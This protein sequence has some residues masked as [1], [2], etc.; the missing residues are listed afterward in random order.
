MPTPKVINNRLLQKIRKA[1]DWRKLFLALDLVRDEQRSKPDDWWT[2]SPFA[3]EKTASFHM[4]SNGWYCHST[5]Q[6]GGPIELVQ[7]LLEYRT[8]QP[9]NC[10]EAGRWLLEH[11]VSEIEKEDTSPSNTKSAVLK[12]RKKN[13]VQEQDP[14]SKGEERLNV[15]SPNE[16]IRQDLVPK[17]SVEHPELTNRGISPSTCVY[18]GCG[19]LKS[20]RGTINNRIVFQVRG[21]Q[22]HSGK[23]RSVILTHIGRATSWVQEQREGKWH[24]FARFHKT[25][26]LYNIDKV[27][28]DKKAIA[29]VQQ[30]GWIILVEGCFDVAKCVEGGIFN[31]IATFG[32]YLAEEQIPRLKFIA[33]R[34]GITTFLVWYDRDAAG[35][36]HQARAISLL[37]SVGYKAIGFN[38]EQEFTSGQRTVGFP[39]GIK[40]A[41]D[42]SVAQLRWLRSK[43]II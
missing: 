31:V 35:R 38:W 40:D 3:T 19:F 14:G 7:K 37:T 22:E 27:L 28:L 15:S 21:V 11:K 29:Q 16:P 1:Y 18:L 6:G 26:E 10:Y 42:M 43:G 12:N 34:L 9:L 25:A 41:C 17:L 4:N 20:A 32:A 33:E 23:L 8:G 2:W 30:T 24:H 39:P 13:T 5:A 36:D